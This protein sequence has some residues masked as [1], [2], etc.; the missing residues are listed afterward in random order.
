MSTQ[1][2]IIAIEVAMVS[3]KVYTPL[4]SDFTRALLVLVM[5]RALAIVSSRFVM[6]EVRTLSSVSPCIAFRRLRFQR[7]TYSFRVEGLSD[8][9]CVEGRYFS[10]T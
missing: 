9:T 3:A 6:V 7:L 5:S 4:S 2:G 8:R 10:S 1:N